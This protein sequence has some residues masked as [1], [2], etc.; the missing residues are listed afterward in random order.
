[1]IKDVKVKN[2]TIGVHKRNKPRQK[3]YFVTFLIEFEDEP[4]RTILVPDLRAKTELL[5]IQQDYFGTIA[6][7]LIQTW[8][9]S[10]ELLSSLENVS[11]EVICLFDDFFVLK[12]ENLNEVV[13]INQHG[14]KIAEGIINEGK[15]QLDMI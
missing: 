6:D 7:N 13:G 11:G 14:E 3:F 5:F 1:M 4:T 9:I 10:G 2:K 8:N 12:L 15:V